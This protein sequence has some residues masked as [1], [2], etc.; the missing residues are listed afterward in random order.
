VEVACTETFA[1]A[2]PQQ[3]KALPAELGEERRKVRDNQGSEAFGG[4]ATDKLTNGAVAR[5]ELARSAAVLRT[6]A[7]S[8]AI[9]VHS[10]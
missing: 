5:I 3:R 10:R 2:A 6:W 1:A 9:K 4:L 7:Y 8:D